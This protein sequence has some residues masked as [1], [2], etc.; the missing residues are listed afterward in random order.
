MGAKNHGEDIEDYSAEQA[1]FDVQPARDSFSSQHE[2]HL[3]EESKTKRA[4]RV[5]KKITKKEVTDANR[6]TRMSRVGTTKLQYN[7]MSV[8]NNISTTKKS[9][10]QLN[11]SNNSHA[12]RNLSGKKIE[13][14]TKE[15]LDDTVQ[16][17]SIDEGKEIVDVLDEA[18]NCDQSNSTDTETPDREE[19]HIIPPE[20]K[21]DDIIYQKMEELEVRVEKFEDELREVAAI[22]FSIY[23]V[24]AEHAGSGY[25]V[26]T[27]ARRLSKI[28]IHACQSLSED[29][30]ARMARSIVS[31]LVLVAKSCGNDISRL[32]FWLSNTIVLRE[33]IT[34]NLE[35]SSQMDR[36]IKDTAADAKGSPLQWRNGPIGKPDRKRFSLQ[37]TYVWHETSTIITALNK[38]ESWVFSRIIESVWWQALTPHM[39]SPIKKYGD[40][41]QGNFSVNLWLMTFHDAFTRLCPLRAKG[42]KCGCLPALAKLVMQHCISRLDVAMLNAIL[43]EPAIEVPTD[44]ISDPIADPNVLPIPP[45]DLSFGTGAQLRNAIGNWSILLTEKFGMNVEESRKT[46]RDGLDDDDRKGTNELM[47]FRLLHQLSELLMLPKDMLLEAPIRQE[48]C[49]SFGVPLITRILDNFTPDEFCPDPVPSF[50]LDELNSE[51]V[52]EEASDIEKVTSIPCAASAISYHP[53][54]LANTAVELAIAGEAPAKLDKK[55]LS[56][57]MRGYTSEDD[58]RELDLP[59]SFLDDKGVTEMSQ[60]NERYKLLQEIWSE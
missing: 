33:I 49:P 29:K 1:E 53:S 35:K 48:V 10:K 21:I 8:N 7:K 59:L 54:A 2:F 41:K 19:E 24:I 14:E 5:P 4:T 51:S 58:F 57:Q 52:L 11:I 16:F 31:S 12:T 3:T 55:V 46:S 28:F 22:E 13:S 25:E 56:I 45:R 15:V 42:S 47:W 23:S 40:R 38:I 39:Q 36:F 37:P 27:P 18:P 17:N 60:T 20:V 44:P 30:K 32:T 50:V 6:S 26:H 34:Q 9:P 43:R